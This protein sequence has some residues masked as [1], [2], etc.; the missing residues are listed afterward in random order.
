MSVWPVAIQT[1]TPLG[2][3]IIAVS[4]QKLKNPLQRRTVHV[5]V[6]SHATTTKLDLN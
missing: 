6:H 4:F 3:G 1:L 5:T 2:I